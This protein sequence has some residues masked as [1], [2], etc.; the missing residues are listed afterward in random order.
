MPFMGEDAQSQRKR[1]RH[2][3]DYGGPLFT[4]YHPEGYTDDCVNKVD[5]R[6]IL[7]VPKRTKIGVEGVTVLHADFTP[8][9]R[10]RLS[11]QRTPDAKSKSPHTRP[12]TINLSPCHIC[13]RRPTKKSEL[14]SFVECQGCGE[15][16]CFVCIR[17]C[18]GHQVP[19]ED[20]SIMSEQEALSRSFHMEDADAHPGGDVHREKD[21][22]VTSPT[23]W[24][25][26][27]HRSVVC[28]RCCVERG[29]EGE[30]VCLGCLS[31]AGAT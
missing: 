31:T 21:G 3:D 25:A 29:A 13:H 28:N 24:N 4:V 19:D 30:V 22:L 8:S 11:Q 27:N 14:D 10:R 9:H 7:P 12:S 6:K 18:H 5:L 1:R 20:T 16:S 2:D 23:G 17:Q 26:G 15:R